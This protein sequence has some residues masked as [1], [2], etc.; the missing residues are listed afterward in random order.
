MVNS[1]RLGALGFEVRDLAAW[2][3]FAVDVLGLQAEHG[4][5]GMALRCDDRAARFHLTQGPSDDVS[6]LGWE[7]DDASALD[8]T[9]ERLRAAGVETAQGSPAQC[10]ARRVTRLV[11]FRDPSGNPCELFFGAERAATPFRSRH[12]LS[13]FVTGAQGLGHAVISAAEPEA[14]RRFY[15]DVLGFRLSDR[16][17][18]EVHGYPVD[19]AFLHGSTR[20]HS[21]AIGGPQKKRIHHFMLEVGSVDDV[22]L[23][24][25]RAMK[26]GVRIMQ[27]LGRHPND[28]MLSFYARTPSGFQFEL[29]W[30]GRQVDDATWQP[31]TYDR[32]SEW[33]HHP[34]EMLAPKPRAT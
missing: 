6:F 8:A 1:V 26:A 13:S 3:A 16:I 27:T 30:G 15:C 9:V 21:V 17:V 33:G 28:R 34:P 12:V 2:E 11:T 4:P 20:H 7:V 14:S 23:A 18:C 32:I 24:L 5:E 22:G 25:D 31:T 10:R 29:G 19:I